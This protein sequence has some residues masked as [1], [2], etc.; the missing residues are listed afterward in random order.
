MKNGNTLSAGHSSE[1]GFSI[2]ALMVGIAVLMILLG[3][4]M[5]VWHTVVLRDREE[6]LIFRG[7][8]YVDAIIRFYGKNNRYPVSLEELAHSE[9]NFGGQRFVRK[10]WKDPMMEDGRWILIFASHGGPP[11]ITG[12]RG[13]GPMRSPWVVSAAAGSRAGVVPV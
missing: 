7:E 1:G 5:P 13:Q 2:V 8:Q 11:K 12:F 10:L 4:S 3:A 9:G 6:E